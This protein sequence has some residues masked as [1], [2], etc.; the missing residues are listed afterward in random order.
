MDEGRNSIATL[1]HIVPRDGSGMPEMVSHMK[2]YFLVS[3]VSADPLCMAIWSV[4]SLLISYC[5]SSGLA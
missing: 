3:R 5:G 4:L 1:G 2:C